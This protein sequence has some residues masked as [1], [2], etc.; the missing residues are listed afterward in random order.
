[1]IQ[2]QHIFRMEAIRKYVQNKEKTILPRFI[3]PASFVYLWIMLVMI[4]ASSTLIWLARVPVYATGTAVVVRSADPPNSIMVVG[5]FPT[6]QRLNVRVGQRLYLH[7]AGTRMPQTIVTVEDSIVSP[8]TARRHYMLDHGMATAITQP[9]AVVLAQLTLLPSSMP[10]SDYA[11]S[12]VP[13]ELEVGS[14]QFISLFPF[15]D[16]VFGEE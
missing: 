5:F 15:L 10:L 8:E 9:S 13:A 6:E 7:I 14:R 4:L 12:I 1:M 2:K 3:S 16:R 11:G